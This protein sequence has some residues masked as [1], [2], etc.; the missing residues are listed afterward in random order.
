MEVFDDKISFL[1]NFM[2]K[3][4]EERNLDSDN[5]KM[6]KLANNTKMN[7]ILKDLKDHQETLDQ[8]AGLQNEIL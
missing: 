1:S 7:D 6:F 4:N 2:N 8:S 3:E 5:F